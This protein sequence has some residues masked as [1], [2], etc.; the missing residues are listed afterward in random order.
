M[1]DYPSISVVLRQSVGRH[2]T[3]WTTDGTVH[4]G[5]LSQGDSHGYVWLVGRSYVVARHI[6]AW[7]VQ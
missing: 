4:T 3:L 1:D 6:A 2:V 7:E 5:M